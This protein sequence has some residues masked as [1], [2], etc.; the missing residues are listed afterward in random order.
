MEVIPMVP[1]LTKH[2]T[3]RRRID[4]RLSRGSSIHASALQFQRSGKVPVELRLTHIY[5]VYIA[6]RQVGLNG[7]DWSMQ[8]ASE[9]LGVS[10]WRLLRWLENG[11]RNARFGE[12]EKLAA[13]SGV[14][15]YTLLAM[16]YPWSAHQ[17][18]RW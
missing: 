17:R 8:R 3:V 12:I 16:E 1:E 13:L 18:R 5:W 11:L 14:S 15:V 9:R 2:T 6:I 10:R 7:H 4:A